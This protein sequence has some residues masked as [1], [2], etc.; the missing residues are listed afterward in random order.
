MN[1]VIFY[2]VYLHYTVGCIVYVY[3][4]GSLN[5]C[6]SKIGCS[7]NALHTVHI[8]VDGE[9]YILSSIQGQ[10]Y[11]IYIIHTRSNSTI[12]RTKIFFVK[13]VLFKNDKIARKDISCY[14][15]ADE[16]IEVGITHKKLPP[17]IGQ[18]QIRIQIRLSGGI[19]I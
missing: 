11:S 8:L 3:Q 17:D 2:N 1:I 12:S 16:K 15:R 5:I 9:V 10:I 18:I 7:K 6:I 19:Q 14:Q 13:P 4:A